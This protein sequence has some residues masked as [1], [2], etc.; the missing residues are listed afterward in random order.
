MVEDTYSEAFAGICSRVMVTAD[1]DEIITRTAF[2]ATSTPGTVIGRVEGG[3]ESWLEE[4]ETPDGRKGAVL[5]FWYDKEDIENLRW[6]YPTAS[7]RTY[8]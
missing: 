3:I 7:D 2:D 1:D 4:D 6:S 8:W 5:Q